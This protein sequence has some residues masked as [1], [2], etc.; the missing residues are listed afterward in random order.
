M[1]K[2]W[3]GF[4]FLAPDEQAPPML[5]QQCATITSLSAKDKTAKSLPKGAADF[6]ALKQPIHPQ[7]QERLNAFR[8][9]PDFSKL[10]LLG[11][12][13]SRDEH[14]DAAITED[15]PLEDLNTILDLLCKLH[16]AECLVQEEKKEP[17]YSQVEMDQMT[18]ELV[19]VITMLLDLRIPD[20]SRRGR[21]VAEVSDYL[22]KRLGLDEKTMRELVLAAKLRELGKA[23][24][25]DELLHKSRQM[26]SESEKNLYERYPVW[27]GIVLGGMPGLRGSASMIYHHLEKF[28]GT[29][30]PNNLKGEAIPIGSR[31]LHIA[32]TFEVVATD[33]D[34]STKTAMEILERGANREFDPY[35]VKLMHGYLQAATAPDWDTNT[36]RIPLAELEE[37]Q[38]LAEDL[39]T[40]SG[41]KL[42]PQ[43]A[44]LT[45]HKVQLIL[46]YR[47][48]EPVEETVAIYRQKK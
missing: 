39:W 32:A 6:I 18:D 35:L 9:N 37:G 5:L 41:V 24:L 48:S 16:Q 3:Q 1:T 29:G 45:Q 2:K 38:I 28:D 44:K 11:T 22:G 20:A 15:T 36:I 42:L 34:G 4:Y 23:G 27:G 33:V 21:R 47:S 46:N 40:R 13:A 8:A 12:G 30:H 43:G 14:V 19:E 31:I 25:S 26:R 7:V 17:V 10:P